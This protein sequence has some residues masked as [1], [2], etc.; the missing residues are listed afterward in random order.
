MAVKDI[1]TTPNEI[2]NKKPKRLGNID[3]EIINIAKI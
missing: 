3:D 1:V 2:L